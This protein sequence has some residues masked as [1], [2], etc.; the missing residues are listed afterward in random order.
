MMTLPAAIAPLVAGYGWQR[1]AAG[2]SGA[3]VFRLAREG[4]PTR[5][6]KSWTA[7]ACSTS[8]SELA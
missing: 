7:T 8:S 2:E 4:G 3:R 6:R 5:T 1:V